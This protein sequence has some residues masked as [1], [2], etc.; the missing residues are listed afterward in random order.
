MKG[1]LL[2]GGKGSRLGPLTVAVSKQL[3]PVYSQPMVHYSLSTVLL[4][5]V[6]DLLLISDRY[7]LGGFQKLLGDGRRFGIKIAYEIQDKP[8]GIAESILIAEKFLE[9]QGCVLALGDNIFHGSGL[10]AKLAECGKNAG[11][12][13]LAS[14]VQ[15]PSAY[16]VVQFSDS[17]LAI[18]LEEKPVNP[19]SKYAVP[20]LYFYDSQVVS[21]AKSLEPSS[22]GELEI[23]DLN[24]V[25]LEKGQLNVVALGRGVAWIDSGTVQSLAEA[26]EYVKAIEGRHGQKV[27][28]PEEVAWNLGL[29]SASELESTARLFEKSEY[30]QYLMKLL[31]GS[32]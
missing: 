10:G 30:G 23:T 26:T 31:E 2:A 28:C 17:G 9:G 6:T 16:G 29:I 12:S 3:L 5:G 27:S 22:R 18:S 32:S 24:K 13:I 11:A 25:Y 1:I 7:S 19:K 15:N 21:I 8:N 20:G 14:R 4:A